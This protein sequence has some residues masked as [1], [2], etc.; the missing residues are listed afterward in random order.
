MQTY[1]SLGANAIEPDINVFS[2]GELC[3]DHGPKLWSG[4]SPDSAPSLVK[5]LTELR[6]V[7]LDFRNLSLVYFDCKPPVAKAGHGADLLEAIRTQL[8]GDGRDR[9]N[10][11]VIISVADLSEQLIFQ[12]IAGDLRPGE[13]LMIDQDNDPGAVCKLFTDLRARKQC[14][15][16]G[17]SVEN[18]ESWLA[19]HIRS[20][21]EQ[22]CALRASGRIS[23][24]TT[25]TVN[26][27]DLMSEYIKI[28]VDGM[29]VD[30][31]PPWYNPG[32]G[33]EALTSLVA[34]EG[35]SLGIR[36]ATR[37]DSPF[38]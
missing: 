17:I 16:N 36:M 11:S 32:Q 14:F 38:A 9:L 10:L 4:P 30:R 24:V 6:T 19:P 21:I 26:D 34:R 12:N 20:S 15:S 8:I 23:L 25:W 1:L 27:A 28:G 7:A 3:V 29:I 5:Y 22:A 35:D 13:A 2:S 33:I 31:A 18:G 37:A